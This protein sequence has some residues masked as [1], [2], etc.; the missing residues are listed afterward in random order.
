MCN[1]R[2]HS[3]GE[4]PTAML[5]GNQGGIERKIKRLNAIRA[6]YE[7]DLQDLKKRLKNDSITKEKYERLSALTESK[8][9]KILSQVKKLRER[10]EKFD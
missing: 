1:I 3:R 6:E 9:D 5:G 4:L 2:G 7:D 8:V 10:R